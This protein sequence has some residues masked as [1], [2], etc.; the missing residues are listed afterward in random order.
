MTL[1]GAWTRYVPLAR[2]LPHYSRRYLAGDL[3]AG[4]VVAALA[5]PQSL[6]YAG[7][8]G[9]PVIVGLYAIPLALIAYAV[10]GSSPH[11]VVGPVS[12]VSVLTGSLVADMS[13]G[14]PGMAVAFAAA[15]AIG[16][17]I[18]LLIGGL[19]RLGWAAEFMSRPIVTGFVFGLVILIIIGEIPSLVGIPAPSGR[20]QERV[21]AILV[22]A[23]DIDPL[24]ALLGVGALVI[25]FVGARLAP[26]I[27]WG[28]IVLVGGIAASAYWDLGARGV[29]TVGPV[30]TGLPPLGLPDI[31]IGDIPAVAFGGLALMMVGLA[32]GLSAA[33][34]FAAREGYTID[35]NQE[36]LATGAA[37]IA[38]GFSGG[39]GVAG[40]LSKTAAS[41]R[42][43][44]QTQ[45]TGIAASVI[46]LICLAL[47][48]NLLAPLPRA[49][50][51][52]IVIQ[53]VWG[54]M[55]VSALRRY[56]SIRRNDF[57]AAIA[58]MV[59]VLV[60]GPLYG[61]LVAV[62]L[63]VLGLVYRSSRVE[64]DIMGKVPGEKAAWG[65]I[66]DHPERRTY[67]GLVV[68]RL[69]VPLFWAN[70]TEIHDR[71]L[72]TLDAEPTVRVLLLDLEA[73]SQLDTTSIDMLELLLTRLR[74]RDVDLYLVRVFYRARRTLT[75]AGFIEQ[76]GEDH[77]WHS[78]SAGVR[79]ARS[80]A[81]L[82]GKPH[83]Q[84]GALG[85]VPG[86][87]EDADD[88][89]QADEPGDE[90]IVV[91]RDV[92]AQPAEPPV[93]AAPRGGYQDPDRQSRA[94]T[95]HRFGRRTG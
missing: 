40:S 81:R 27:P 76:L 80:A 51:S 46:V 44:G 11:L 89:D 29:V 59:G 16:A 64:T 68:M 77:M 74:E 33:R 8:A 92:P 88:A 82:T 70:A 24:T 10:L 17:G 91:D 41:R 61:L 21:L 6:G 53:A 3:L 31:P 19:A 86:D 56:Q 49:I 78:I 23:T 13:R 54:L 63:A 9:V 47:L 62:G 5:I 55:D 67:D 35:T 45:L 20:V 38:A 48:A 42:S 71:V 93:P 12:T 1:T 30:P 87:V 79:A 7:I 32:E 50:L 95:R 26:R 15:L 73:T 43:G 90:R 37:N 22:S 85:G 25:L 66:D 52:A 65:S 72:A 39:L 28:L 83:P 94:A 58:A 2:W 60:L 4:L 34:L 69:D 75:Q 57:V 18:G 14:E 84:A 36:L